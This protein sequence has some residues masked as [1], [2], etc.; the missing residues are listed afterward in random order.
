MWSS[1]IS[2]GS[3]SAAGNHHEAA[4]NHSNPSTLLDSRIA[5]LTLIP[6]LACNRLIYQ[7][8][9]DTSTH[10]RTRAITER[11]SCCA[12]HHFSKPKGSGFLSGLALSIQ[13]EHRLVASIHPWEVLCPI[14]S[15]KTRFLSGSPC[16]PPAGP[17]IYG[18]RRSTTFLSLLA[19]LLQ[20]TIKP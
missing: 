5:K 16:L 11:N 4:P 20:K 8:S 7:G 6:R 9:N 2:V 17:L 13:L 10:K 18:I 12:T 19:L 1:R 14:V 15:Q 3:T